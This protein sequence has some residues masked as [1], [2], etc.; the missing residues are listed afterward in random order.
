AGGRSI[1]DTSQ[2]SVSCAE[3][4]T[5]SWTW[6]A[7]SELTLSATA[8]PGYGF[9]RWTG[10]PAPQGDTCALTVDAPSRVG[11]VFARPLRV[12]GFHL[13]FSRDRTQLSATLHLSEAGRA[14]S[15]VRTFAHQR[16][17]ASTVRGLVATCTWSVPSR[18]RGHRLLGAVELDST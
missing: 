14:D 15:V 18:F 1:V 3:A 4:P 6:Q 11:A 5:C 10:C 9:V 8:A 17:L 2:S 16:V 12:T 7:G 13:A